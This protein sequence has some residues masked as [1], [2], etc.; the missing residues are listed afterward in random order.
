MRQSREGRIDQ[1]GRKTA[2]ATVLTPLATIVPNMN[3]GDDSQ[4][5]SSVRSIT[6]DRMPTGFAPAAPQ[7]KRDECYVPDAGDQILPIFIKTKRLHTDSSSTTNQNG[8]LI[9]IKGEHTEDNLT[10]DNPFESPFNMPEMKDCECQTRESLFHSINFSNSSADNSVSPS[11]PLPQ[12]TSKFAEK[13]LKESNQKA[14]GMQTLP[15]RS[16]T[17]QS[18]FTTFG[19]GNKKILPKEQTFRAEAVI[20]MNKNK[21]KDGSASESRPF[22]IQSTKSAPDVIVTH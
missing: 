6:P 14:A 21:D 9:F 3:R 15:S 4:T 7:L 20:E 5:G 10:K 1:L 18:S 19:Y 12:I 22:S 11:P 13:R 8:D 16:G 2:S 17:N